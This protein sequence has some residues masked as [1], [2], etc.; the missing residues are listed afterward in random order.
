MQF[1]SQGRGGEAGLAAAHSVAP[2]LLKY[3]AVSN[4][5][6]GAL[7][8]AHFKGVHPELFAVVRSKGEGMRKFL[9]G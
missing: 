5:N 1:A 2:T 3:S 4:V 6:A 7:F 9:G 8:M